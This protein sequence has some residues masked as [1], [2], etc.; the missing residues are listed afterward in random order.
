M[1]KDQ[2]VLDLILRSEV[3]EKK[4]AIYELECLAVA[5]ALDVFSSHLSHRN[6]VPFTDN[7]GVHGTLVRCWSDNRIGD[8]LA[9]VCQ[10][11]KVAGNAVV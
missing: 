7:E 8:G 6:I 9:G 10:R 5:I 3:R 2:V 1:K 4:T 11:R